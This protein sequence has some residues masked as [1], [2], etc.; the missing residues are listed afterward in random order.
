[1]WFTKR[2]AHQ[3]VL[4]PYKVTAETRLSKA[5]RLEHYKMPASFS[6]D[7][8]SANIKAMKLIFEVFR[9]EGADI[10]T[11]DHEAESGYCDMLLYK[12]SLARI[13]DHWSRRFFGSSTPSSLMS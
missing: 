6:F 8:I 1:M 5:T 13:P 7:V 4:Q 3:G 12:S 10:V 11:F 9:T 2:G